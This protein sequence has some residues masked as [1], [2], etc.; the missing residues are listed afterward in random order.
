MKKFHWKMTIRNGIVP[1]ANQLLKKEIKRT[2]ISFR[3]L[4]K[5]IKLMKRERGRWMKNKESRMRSLRKKDWRK[6][7]RR[8]NKNRKK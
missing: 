8:K 5:R 7:K 4:M 6:D 3:G 1:D 2:W